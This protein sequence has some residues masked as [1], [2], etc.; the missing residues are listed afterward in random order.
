[1]FSLESR[2]AIARCGPAKQYEGCAAEEQQ[3]ARK[4]T[5]VCGSQF[6]R[7]AVAARGSI[8]GPKEFRT[9]QDLVSV[10]VQGVKL[11]LCESGDLRL[12]FGEM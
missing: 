12:R 4:C 11:Y 10:E 9:A 2:I 7:G 8:H 5:Q 6:V 3:I 1:M